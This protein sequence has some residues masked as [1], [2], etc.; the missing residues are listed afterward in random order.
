MTVR[1]DVEKLSNEILATRLATLRRLERRSLLPGALKS[2]IIHLT[3][4]ASPEVREVAS[5]LLE[6]RFLSPP[7][8]LTTRTDDPRELVRRCL[9]SDLVES[10]ESARALGSLKTK[11]ADEALFSLAR[12]NSELI[13]EAVADGLGRRARTSPSALRSLRELTSDV[14][15]RV[16][17]AAWY[18]IARLVSLEAEEWSEAMVT[19]LSDRLWES[20]Y[21]AA[22]SVTR[23]D[24]LPSEVRL[25]IEARYEDPT[26]NV[27]VESLHAAWHHLRVENP[28]CARMAALM[29]NGRTDAESV[30][31]TYGS[32]MTCHCPEFEQA[33]LRVLARGNTS[34][35][36][37]AAAS[38]ISL[39]DPRSGALQALLESLA[40]G[41]AEL[42]KRIARLFG[43][44]VDLADETIPGLC[45]ALGHR[46]SEV[47][48]AAVE[49][50]RRIGRG[51]APV[52]AGLRALLE[53]KKPAVREATR[54]AL[55]RLSRPEQPG[56]A[57]RHSADS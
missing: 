23:L 14:G 8:R 3:L 49:S 39:P 56:S 22:R 10:S 38:L 28:F 16:R 2:P 42:R 13:R 46:N 48:L 32:F 47:R 29:K 30:A 33:L 12:H 26:A 19:G 50:L 41:P 7:F 15:P 52:L 1:D 11:E 35:R 44:R 5:R 27:R 4:D 21:W 18:E 45:A 43:E 17:A 6:T 55:D 25:A 57:P 51:T 54:R 40:S 9:A 31:V 34:A 24:R 36:A 20:R 37:E 53:D